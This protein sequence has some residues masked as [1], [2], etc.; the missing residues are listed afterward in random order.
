MTSCLVCNGSL[1]DHKICKVLHEIEESDAQKEIQVKTNEGKV[2][3]R[4]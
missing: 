3:I 1:P 4:A 2:R